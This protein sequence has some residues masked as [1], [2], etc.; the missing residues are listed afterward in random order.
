MENSQKKQKLFTNKETFDLLH[1][2]RRICGFTPFLVYRADEKS[3]QLSVKITFRDVLCFVGVVS[4]N[5][6]FGIKNYRYRILFNMSNTFVTS[7]GTI[8]VTF[9][10]FVISVGCPIM[11][12]INRKKICKLFNMVEAWDINVRFFGYRIGEF[13]NTLFLVV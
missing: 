10:G 7:M 2:F 8:L 9:C 3:H 12:V 13:L 1:R 11:N 5:I 6:L 4:I